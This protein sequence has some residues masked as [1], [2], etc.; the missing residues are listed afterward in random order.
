M[1]LDQISSYPVKSLTFYMCINT[2]MS[3]FVPVQAM[4]FLNLVFIAHK[5]KLIKIHVLTREAWLFLSVVAK[6][7]KKSFFSIQ[8]VNLQKMSIKHAEN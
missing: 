3:Q 5:S 2:H 7:K 8:F 1:H 4:T 6:K